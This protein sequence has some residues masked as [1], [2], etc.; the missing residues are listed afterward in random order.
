MVYKRYI[1]RDGKTFGPYYYESYRDDKGKTRT[2]I[3]NIPKKNKFSAKLIYVLIA[4]SLILIAGFFWVN[5]TGITLKN[6]PEKSV[7]LEETSIGNSKILG[8][9]IKLIG[10]GVSETEDSPAQ[11]EKTESIADEN[12]GE[13]QEII[14]SGYFRSISRN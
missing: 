8:G 14:E 3:V 2:K 7:N 9:F 11:S 6:N 13:Q 5:H 4:F 12:T 10:F 1:K